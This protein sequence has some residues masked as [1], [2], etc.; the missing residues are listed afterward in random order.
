MSGREIAATVQHIMLRN[1]LAYADAATLFRIRQD[2]GGQTVLGLPRPAEQAAPVAFLRT[3]L[4]IRLPPEH[5]YP[6]HH[7]M[8]KPINPSVRRSRLILFVASFLMLYF[9]LAV[10]RWIPGQVRVIAYFTNFVLI[11]CFFGMGVGMLLASSRFDAVR[12]AAPGILV[13]VLLSL[14]FKGVWVYPRGDVEN[15][16]FLE[17]EGRGATHAPLYYT[18]V[19]F[20]IAIAA[21]FVPF[22]QA[23]GRCF[24]KEAPLLDYAANLLGSMAGIVAFSLNAWFGLPAWVW[25]LLGLLL[26]TP[27][28]LDHRMVRW[29]TPGIAV[30]TAALVWNV[31]RGTIWSP[32]HKVDVAPMYVDTDPASVSALSPITRTGGNAVRLSPE[33]GFNVRIND[34]FYQRPVNLSDATVAQYPSLRPLRDQYDLAFRLKPGARRVL[35]VGGGTGNDAA[36]ALRHG[37]ERV[38][39]VDIDPTIVDIGRRRHPERPYDDPRVR[40]YVDDARHFFHYAQPGYDVVVFALL[41]SHRLFS[42]FSSLRLDSYVFTLESFREAKRLLAPDGVQVT[43]FAGGMPWIR[44]RFYEMLRAEYGAEPIVMHE[45]GGPRVGVVYVSGPGKVATGLAVRPRPVNRAAVLCTDDWPFVYAKGRSIPREYLLTLG[46]VLAASVVGLRAATGK[47]GMPNL[48]FFFLG[49][50]FMLLETKNVTTVAL[51]FGSTWYVNA[52]VFLS[53]LAMALL[54]CLVMHAVRAVPIWLA[55]VGLFAAIG[56]NLVVPLQEF[57]GETLTQRLLV[58]GGVTALP[59]FFSGIVFAHSFKRTGDPAH[60]LGS[61]VLGG[62]CGGVLEYLS[63][64]TGLRFLLYLIAGA[65]GLSIVAIPR[66]TGHRQ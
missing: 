54:A 32:Y 36:A 61:N 49:V 38:D 13:L 57:V 19:V 34:D 2:P 29:L 18:L 6:R 1:A 42:A 62:V 23:I 16:L 43:A 41:D 17:Y 44:E 46:L 40:V 27:L 31:A 55:Y 4:A 59:L 48:H 53:I 5:R 8:D 35:I 30:L 37:A 63:M 14:F 15:F 10:I 3:A 56:Q 22:G 39:V 12:W 45:H 24:G 20:Y 66:R 51:A 52:V 25:F 65:Y 58:V 33:V 64:V 60:A 9:E 26:V 47:A 11:A 7:K 28:V 50:G 21:A